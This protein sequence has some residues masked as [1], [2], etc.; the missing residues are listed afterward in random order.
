MRRSSSVAHVVGIIS[1]IAL[2][3][4][5][6]ARYASH[7]EGGWR[8][9]YV[10][11][12]VVALY[13]NVFVLIVQLFAKQPAL[14]AMSPMQAEPPFLFAQLA[15]LGLFVALWCYRG[16]QIPSRYQS[17]GKTGCEPRSGGR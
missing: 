8:S 13:L 4:A 17:R 14:K 12:A 10:I 7:L 16:A 11:S 3:V 1:L 9:A 5:V 15:A 2:V 6:Y